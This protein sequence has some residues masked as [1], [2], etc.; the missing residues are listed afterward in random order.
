MDEPKP[1]HVEPTSETGKLLERAGD[2][3]LTVESG[4]RLY[5]IERQERATLENYDPAKALAGLRSG[6]GLYDGIDV[7]EAMREIR[8]QRDQDS[9]GRPGQ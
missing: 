1:I 9:R 8:M 3:P 6:I 5:R 7:Q 4:G 2:L